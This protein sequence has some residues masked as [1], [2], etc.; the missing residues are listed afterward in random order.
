MDKKRLFPAVF[1]VFVNL[2]GATVIL[3][4]LPLFVVEQLGGTVLQA[5]L[6]DSSYYGAK[7][8]A[9]PVLGRLSDRYGR[10][11][12]LLLCQAG[13]AAAFLLFLAALPI[14][15]RLYAVG[16]PL[17]VHPA[18]LLFYLARI[19]RT[20]SP[21]V[22][23]ASPRRMSPTSRRT[24]NGQRRSVCSPPPSASVLSPGRRSA[25]SLPAG[26]D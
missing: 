25:A 16:W 7:L 2:W 5:V 12:L 8:L 1:V 14:A 6:L 3:P 10:R 13:T 24:R 26:G 23:P 18:L 17:A 22:I 9:A 21:A 15:D 4:I 11:P 20:A 19:P